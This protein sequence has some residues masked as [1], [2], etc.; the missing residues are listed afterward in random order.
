MNMIKDPPRTALCA[1]GVGYSIAIFQQL[2]GAHVIMYYAAFIFQRA[3]FFKV[4]FRYLANGIDC[5]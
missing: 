5:K 3:E 1:F 2:T 4:R